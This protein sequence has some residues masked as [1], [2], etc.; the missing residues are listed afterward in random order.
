MVDSIVCSLMLILFK[1]DKMKSVKVTC[2]NGATWIT[3]VSDKSTPK[4]KDAYFVGEVF[5]TGVY[6]SEIMSK[7]ISAEYVYDHHRISETIDLI[8]KGLI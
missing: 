3:S 2:E 5:N 4:S 8:S 1:G 7:C 6:P